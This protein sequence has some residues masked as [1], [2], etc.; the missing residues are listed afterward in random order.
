SLQPAPG[1]RIAHLTPTL[2]LIGKIVDSVIDPPGSC[3]GW[4]AHRP[5]GCPESPD[6]GSRSARRFPVRKETRWLALVLVGACG[7]TASA[8]SRLMYGVQAYPPY[9]QPVPQAYY[10][11]AQ[12]QPRVVYVQATPVAPAAK[13]PS[14]SGA[15]GNPSANSDTGEV[16]NRKIPAKAASL[17][18]D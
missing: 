7:T 13:A 11:Y 8:Q 10:Y 15:A 16:S 1:K 2:D 3:H 18:Q 5:N 6:S 4:N 17:Q 14:D 12:P 9:A